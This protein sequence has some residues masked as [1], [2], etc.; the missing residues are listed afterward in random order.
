VLGT[1]LGCLAGLRCGTSTDAASKKKGIDITAPARIQKLLNATDAFKNIVSQQAD[2]PIGFWPKDDLTLTIG[3]LAWMNY[4]LLLP[5][6]RPLLLSTGKT[7][8]EVKTLLEQAHHDLYYPIVKPS[9]R[10]HVV[11]AIKR[12]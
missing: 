11:H 5:A 6:M 8:S 9:S 4:D 12:S 10:L 2:I 3:Q 7:E 1:H